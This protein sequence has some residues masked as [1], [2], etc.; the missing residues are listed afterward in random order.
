MPSDLVDKVLKQWGA[1]RPDL[2]PRPL[3]VVGRIL[4][5]AG[6]FER[7]AN[8]SLRSL[9]LPIWAFDMLGTLYRQGAPYS[10]TPSQLAD[11]TMLTSGA[12]T[13][14][15]D[16]LEQQGLVVRK[17][18]LDDRRSLSV[19]LTPKGLSSI[20]L[21]APIRFQEAADAVNG[22]T[23]RE[24]K[25]LAGLLRTLLASVEPETK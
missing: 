4:R 16:R 23:L 17:P 8:S 10:M 2:N 12:M 9:G 15:I 5:I 11:S 19:S 13:N 24:Q 3:A 21:A 14:R 25:Q 22:L 7:R 20:E 18:S 1:E 6:I